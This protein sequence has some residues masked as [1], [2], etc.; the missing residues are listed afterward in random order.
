MVSPLSS[1]MRFFPKKFFMRFF[2]GNFWGGV[3]VHGV[4]T[5]KPSQDRQSFINAFCNKLNIANRFTDC[6]RISALTRTMEGFILGLSI[7]KKVSK[8]ASSSLSLMLTL[9]WGIRV[10]QMQSNGGEGG[11]IWV[12]WSKQWGDM[13]ELA[14]FFASGEILTRGNSGNWY[15][16]WKVNSRNSGLNLKNTLYTLCLVSLFNSFSGYLH[17]DALIIGLSQ[18]WLNIGQLKWCIN[19]DVRS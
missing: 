11:A 13:G 4:V 1:M 8:V 18:I 15:I 10:S 2:G 12:K 17:F 19:G 16:I 6:V 14:K 3:V 9:I 7:K 5:I